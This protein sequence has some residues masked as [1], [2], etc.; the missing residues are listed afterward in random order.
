[1]FSWSAWLLYLRACQL[2]NSSLTKSKYINDI[3]TIPP[4]GARLLSLLVAMFHFYR[5]CQIYW[6]R[7]PKKFGEYNRPFTDYKRY[8]M[9]MYRA[10]LFTSVSLLIKVK[11][12][13]AKISHIVLKMVFAKNLPCCNLI[14]SLLNSAMLH[15]NSSLQKS[16]MLHLNLTFAKICNVGLTFDIWENLSFCA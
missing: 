2:Q 15:L 14:W 3:N 13:F 1:M 4:I 11:L 6:W 10:H 12:A 5:D 9:K 16:A 7:K 8:H